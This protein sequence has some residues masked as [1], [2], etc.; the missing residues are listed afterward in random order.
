MMVTG[1]CMMIQN[2]HQ[3]LITNI[4]VFLNTMEMPLGEKTKDNTGFAIV[5][6]G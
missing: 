2:I 5:N 4:W 6:N 1:S 3:P